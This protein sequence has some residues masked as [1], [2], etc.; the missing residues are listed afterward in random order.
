MFSIG[1]KIVIASI[2][3][4]IIC[5][6]N[7]ESFLGRKKHRVIDVHAV[8]LAQVRDDLNSLIT[9]TRMQL[10]GHPTPGVTTESLREEYDTIRNRVQSDTELSRNQG[11]QRQL[12]G[13]H[14]L[15]QDLD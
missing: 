8:N 12:N 7:V 3:F 13:L 5:E 14:A 4:V 2:L 10:E 11:I 9:F 15:M 6:F 1:S